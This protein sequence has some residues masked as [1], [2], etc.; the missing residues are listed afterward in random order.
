MVTVR[1][2]YSLSEIVRLMRTKGEDQ[3]LLRGREI[4]I[5]VMVPHIHRDVKYISNL[6]YEGN[7]MK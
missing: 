5:I 3:S 1:T 7:G 4:C 6:G 2:N